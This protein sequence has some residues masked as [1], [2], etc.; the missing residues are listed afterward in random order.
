MREYKAAITDYDKAIEVIEDYD[1]SLEYRDTEAAL[2]WMRGRVKLKLEEYYEA[3]EDFSNAKAKG[4]TL[5]ALHYR[6]WADACCAYSDWEGALYYLNDAIKLKVD[7]PTL[8]TYRA[9]LYHTL[10]EYEDAINDYNTAI[11]LNPNDAETYLARGLVKYEAY[12]LDDREDEAYVD[13]DNAFKLKPT[14]RSEDNIDKSI[15]NYFNN[16][17]NIKS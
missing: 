12:C 5:T 14:L 11:E 16:W 10:R 9:E 4:F 6:L 13:L 1:E 15:L 17:K 7:D 2:Y 3:D 8:Y